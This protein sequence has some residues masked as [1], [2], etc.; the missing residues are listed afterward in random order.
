MPITIY[1]FSVKP[2]TKES[3]DGDVKVKFFIAISGICLGIFEGS[4]GS[5][6]AVPE[7][8]SALYDRGGTR[9]YDPVH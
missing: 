1:F 7:R 3:T 5:H 8:M 4:Y 6:R 9:T 2:S